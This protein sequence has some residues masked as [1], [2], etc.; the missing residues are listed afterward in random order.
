MCARNNTKKSLKICKRWHSKSEYLLNELKNLA[1]RKA[2]SHT[3]V[4]RI[5][6]IFYP[7]S[8]TSVQSSCLF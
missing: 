3:T 7:T 4:D 6:S 2:T 1:N 5:A 8:Y